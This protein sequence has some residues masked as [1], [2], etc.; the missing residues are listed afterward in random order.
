MSQVWGL[1]HSH[2][3]GFLLVCFQQVT[4]SSA[5]APTQSQSWPAPSSTQHF[6]GTPGVLQS[7][8]LQLSV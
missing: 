5:A 8:S 4:P 3:V 1:P 6:S 7:W 2:Q